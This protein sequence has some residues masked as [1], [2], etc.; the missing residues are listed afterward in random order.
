MSPRR[1]RCPRASVWLATT[2]RVQCMFCELAEVHREG[3]VRLDGKD[4]PILPDTVQPREGAIQRIPLV[5]VDIVDA[6]PLRIWR[7]E[8]EEPCGAGNHRHQGV[9]GLVSGY[10]CPTL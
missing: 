10:V 8:C 7:A 6:Q 4:A 3:A 2:V 1:N 5:A 9:A